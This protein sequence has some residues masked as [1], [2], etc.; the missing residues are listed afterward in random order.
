MSSQTAQ[1]D[2]PTEYGRCKFKL[3]QLVK[4]S[5][6]YIVRPGQ[7]Y[8]GHEGGQFGTFVK[9]LRK[10]VFYPKLLPKPFI[11]PIHVD[12]LAHALLKVSELPP[13]EGQSFNVAEQIP[14]EFDKFLSLVSTQWVKR[15]RIGLALPRWAI[16]LTRL[17]LSHS[18]L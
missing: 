6:G 18:S 1:A 2:A 17:T 16:A 8:G 11:Q 7:V 10:S 15:H 14:I 4:E 9:F 5:G 12:D 3:E 13:G